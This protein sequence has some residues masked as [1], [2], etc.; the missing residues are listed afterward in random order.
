MDILE[1]TDIEIYELGIKK[2]KEQMGTTYAMQ[3]LQKCKPRDYDYTA[4]RH[5][6]LADDPDIPTIVKQIK[7]EK[8]LQAK[9]ERVKAERIVA[10]RSGLLELTDIEIYELGFKVLADSLGA[11][12]LLRFITRHFKH[13][14][15]DQSIGLPH[16]TSQDSHTKVMPNRRR[17][18]TDLQD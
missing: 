18:E 7:E 5:K 9:E 8:A 2:L 10:W 13:R 17:R 6:W 1:M 3:F 4:E 12:G 14:G 11:Y 16:Q 15:E